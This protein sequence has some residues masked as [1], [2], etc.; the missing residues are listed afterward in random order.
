[1]IDQFLESIK[2]D[3]LV[4]TTMFGYEVLLANTTK[5]VAVQLVEL[6]KCHVDVAGKTFL[7]DAQRRFDT[8]GWKLLQIFEDEIKDRLHCVTSRI[9]HAFGKTDLVIYARKCEIIQLSTDKTRAFLRTHH[10]QGAGGGGNCLGL[11]AE[12]ELVAVMTFGKARFNKL[13][14]HEL[15]RF[16]SHGG[17]SIP[18]GAAKLLTEVKQIIGPGKLLVSYADCRYGNGNTYEKIG[19]TKTGFSAPCYWYF[20]PGQ[21]KRYHRS[22][23][24]KHKL[25]KLLEHFDP[26]KTELEN[27]AE[28]GWLRIFDSGN[29][30]FM[31]ET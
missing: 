17:L 14:T 26:E 24:Q 12:G 5:K 25:A 16:A 18:G 20:K 10:L 4:K 3:G 6:Q 29:N 13:A 21:L 7:L 1:M 31:L 28:N 11:Q 19:F 15:I 8:E 2:I 9:R 30:V 27:M 23:F 22:T